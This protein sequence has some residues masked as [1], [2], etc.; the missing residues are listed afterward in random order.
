MQVAKLTK[1]RLVAIFLAGLLLLFSPIVSLF[2][3]PTI[4]HGLPILYLYLFAVW[5]A[6]I[7]AMAFA[8]RGGAE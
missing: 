7:V 4:V 1:Q 2:D 8:L 3:R 5:L 6:L